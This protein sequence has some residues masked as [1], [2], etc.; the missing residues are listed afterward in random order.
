M[1]LDTCQVPAVHAGQ[2]HRLTVR[3]EG[4]TITGWVDNKDI[5]C[6]FSSRRRHTIFDCDWSSDVC[7]SDLVFEGDE[8]LGLGPDEEAIAFWQ[9]LGIDRARIVE[10]PRSENFWQ[11][12]PAGPCGPSSELYIDRGVQ[13]G[14]VEDLPGGENARFLEYWNLVFMQYDQEPR[15]GAG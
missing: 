13:H 11:A 7:S 8:E 2:W 4:A 5:V 14:S 1:W 15:P 3:F 6:F 12:G 9:A 10:C